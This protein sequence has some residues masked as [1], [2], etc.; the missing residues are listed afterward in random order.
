[1]LDRLDPHSTLLQRQEW[2]NQ[3]RRDISLV[4]NIEDLW[5]LKGLQGRRMD[6]ER[7]WGGHGLGEQPAT[8]QIRQELTYVSAQKAWALKD[9][10]SLL[11]RPGLR[12]EIRSKWNVNE[13]WFHE[14]SGRLP[15]RLCTA[16]TQPITLYNPLFTTTDAATCIFRTNVGKRKMKI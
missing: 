12:P 15:R 4:S 10:P 6:Q 3:E 7:G 2:T 1:M 16:P 9:D 14:T 11:S 5:R 13:V 8:I